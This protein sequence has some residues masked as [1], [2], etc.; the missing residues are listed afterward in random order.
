M[1]FWA[2]VKKD[3]IIYKRNIKR[4]VTEILVPMFL[5]FI[6]VLIHWNVPTDFR[7]PPEKIDSASVILGPLA[8]GKRMG[9]ANNS[10][11]MMVDSMLMQVADYK[12]F[13]EFQNITD[14][15]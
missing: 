7:D 3:F 13:Y 5:I 10:R 6:L 11:E 14:P 2:M 15:A 1:H 12:D 8:N 9:L 4:Q